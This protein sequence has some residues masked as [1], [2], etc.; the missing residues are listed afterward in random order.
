MAILHVERSYFV[1]ELPV[2][3]LRETLVANARNVEAGGNTHNSDVIAPFLADRPLS[4]RLMDAKHLTLASASHRPRQSAHAQAL[5]TCG[6][7]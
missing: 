2:K 1:T 6:S 3:V 7:H 5:S 4:C